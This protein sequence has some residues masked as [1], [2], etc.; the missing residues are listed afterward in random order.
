LMLSALKASIFSI[1]V[2]VVKCSTGY[3]NLKNAFADRETRYK[4]L[5]VHM[6]N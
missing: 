1:G 2:Y 4:Y 5:P 6:N 3:W